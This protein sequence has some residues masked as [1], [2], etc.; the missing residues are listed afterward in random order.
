[1]KRISTGFLPAVFALPLCVSADIVAPDF[2][3]AS[4][5][6]AVD[7]VQEGALVAGPYSHGVVKT[8][9]GT[10]TLD[11]DR[12]IGSGAFDLAVIGGKVALTSSGAPVPDA[13][14]PAAMEKAALWLKSDSNIVLEDD[15]THVS[16]WRDA[17]STLSDGAWSGEYLYAVGEALSGT[18]D[19]Q[20]PVMREDGE[21][22]DMVY[23][24]G[25]KSGSSMSF[26]KSDGSVAGDIESVR[27]VFL[28]ARIVES[29]GY[30][31]GSCKAGEQMYFCPGDFSGSTDNTLVS[32]LNVSPVTVGG[33]FFLDGNPADLR[34]EK[35]SPGLK[36]LEWSG[37]GAMSVKVGAIFRDRNIGWSYKRSGGD[38]IGEVVVFT[39]DLTTAE[40][41]SVERYLLAKWKNVVPG[42][43]G[44]K[45][46]F[47][48][49]AGLVVDNAA[50]S[51]AKVA[52]DG[53][54]VVE[55]RGEGTVELACGDF[56]APRIS[57]LGGSALTHLGTVG[58]VLEDG[59]DLSHAE[60]AD[61]KT[62][63][64]A[65]VRSVG[66]EGRINLSGEARYRLDAIPSETERLTVTSGA[67]S[68]TA[69]GTDGAL[70]GIASDEVVFEDPSFEKS[71]YLQVADGAQASYNGWTF[72]TFANNVQG[73]V[74]YAYQL[75]FP[76]T[77]WRAE[78][79]YPAPHGTKVLGIKGKADFWTSVTLPKRG[80]YELS[81]Q[82]CK[83]TSAAIVYVDV[84]AVQ[85][86]V[87]N[88][89]GRCR[90]VTGSGFRPHRFKTPILE[91][92]EC[93]L[94]FG[95]LKDEDC[96]PHFDDFRM[97]YLPQFSG[98]EIVPVPNGNFE[99]F[100]FAGKTTRNATVDSCL[101]NNTVRG[102]TLVNIA[103]G[104]EGFRS[105]TP[106]ADMMG[107]LASMARYRGGQNAYGVCH[108]LF[109]D[110]GSSAVTEKA[111]K[112][113]KGRWKLRMKSCGWVS[114]NNNLPWN[115]VN[116]TGASSISAAVSVNGG[117]AVSLGT[118]A[119]DT[120]F[121]KTYEFPEEL[122]LYGDDT[123]TLTLVHGSATAG[124][125][126]DDLE[127]VRQDEL[128]A[129]GDFEDNLGVYWN[130]VS[131]NDESVE[132][133]K[134]S[135]VRLPSS[136]AYYGQMI[137][138]R[139]LL[140]VQCGEVFQDIEVPEAGVYKLEFMTRPRVDANAYGNGS[141]YFVYGG[142]AVRAYL[143]KDGATN[144]IGRTQFVVSTNFVRETFYVEVPAAG[145][146]TLGLQGLNGLP[147]GD[148]THYTL[149][150]NED[151]FNVFD[152]E[153]LVDGVSFKK[154]SLGVAPSVSD[155][156]ELRLDSGTRLYLDYT[157]T[158][159]LKSLRKGGERCYGYID[160][161][162]PSGLV[163]GPGRIFVDPANRIGLTISIR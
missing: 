86:G 142:N 17:R 5:N 95:H 56:G 100:E 113:G 76:M 99:M 107:D 126:V 26:C 2:A 58:A 132:M 39:N 144:E 45:P 35:A 27:H 89:L 51:T 52:V 161:S 96:L 43:A 136:A 22:R 138:E 140:I 131:H 115:G 158:V 90:P 47:G 18:D 40:R 133:L 10:L 69:P 73:Y 65:L 92:G 125:I 94:Y 55:K 129:G 32:Q 33:A 82:A 54:P 4:T 162:D 97:R 141:G 159:E 93:T 44:L 74:G 160:S 128:I 145:T 81:F 148:G 83:R 36:V 9:S 109:N 62:E 147:L 50:G 25:S 48:N 59:V 120:S 49:A 111:F 118:L 87:T 102:W 123:L 110:N 85:N 30:A 24:N 61:A 137:G 57:L 121:L 156:T 64:A 7:T 79:G 23:F 150:S 66:T 124:T 101:S 152:A 146:Y 106:V 112:V 21:G 149:K 72:R 119:P 15:G 88:W 34:Q 135:A 29:W 6:V 12:V 91:A 77:A 139:S 60:G 38:D 3:S 117:E 122:E 143:A 28:V 1:M 104:L 151:G 67:L 13:S 114:N 68:L 20:K 71:G 63:T 78:H 116:L 41:V 19:T 8:G 98:E 105:V 154:S 108:L 130:S 80:V 127:F 157:G 155:E 11:T 46:A 14:V 84:A 16:Q 31:L 75:T 134:R 163:Y 37:L 153:V 53:S 103:A 42:P 70:D